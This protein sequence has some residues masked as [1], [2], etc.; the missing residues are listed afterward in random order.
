MTVVRDVVYDPR[1][2]LTV[3]VYRPPLAASRPTVV[4]LHGGGFIRGDKRDVERIG[5]VLALAGLVAMA[6]AY[7]L[8]PPDVGLPTSIDRYWNAVE[9][10]ETAVRFAREEGGSF[11]VDGDRIG[12]FGTSAGGTLAAMV[13]WRGVRHRRHATPIRA[14]VSWSGSYDMDA[15]MRYPPIAARME[16]LSPGQPFEEVLA[17]HREPLV[18]A[19][20]VTY[21]GLESAPTL[22]VNTHDD[23]VP[24][25]EAEAAARR[26]S[27]A[28]VPSRLIVLA[29]GH[30]RA[31]TRRAILPTLV[32]LHRYLRRRVTD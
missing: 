4:L 10:A 25:P 1:R 16:T 24:L 19:S 26:L 9:D 20:P 30:G 7:R 31:Y 21:V 18:E 11:G 23:L 8:I 2:G 28:G 6:P 5:R 3:D 17:M 29:R 15:A 32:F 14:V 12:L 22:L 27:E 13:G